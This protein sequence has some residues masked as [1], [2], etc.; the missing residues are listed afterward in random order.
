VQMPVNGLV[1]GWLLH[2]S[3]HGHIVRL[4]RSY[5]RLKAEG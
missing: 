2:T 1:T 3:L 5:R 4:S